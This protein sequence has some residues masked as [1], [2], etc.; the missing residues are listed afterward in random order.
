MLLDRLRFLPKTGWRSGRLLS[1]G[2]ASWRP[3]AGKTPA[4]MSRTGH[5]EGSRGGT[6]QAG[7]AGG[8]TDVG[9]R[10]TPL[11]HLTLFPGPIS[12]AS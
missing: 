3:S 5:R 4:E 9:F 2:T 11:I 8:R 7:G 6:V 10:G 1:R 12:P